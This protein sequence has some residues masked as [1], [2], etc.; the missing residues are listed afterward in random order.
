MKK[1]ALILLFPFLLNLSVS[2]QTL[3]K[4]NQYNVLYKGD[5]MPIITLFANHQIINRLGISGYF[6]VNAYPKSSW[7]EGLIG[8][9][10]TVIDGLTLGFLAG[11][12]SNE[13]RI[14]RISPLVM[15]NFGKFSF[16][17]AFEFW[18]KRYRWDAMAF[19]SV[20]SV[21]FGGEFIRYYQMYAA[22]P[23]I[24]FSF[25]KKQPITIFYSFLWDWSYGYP[26]HMF[27]I[28]TSFGKL[29]RAIDFDE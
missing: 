18:G 6:Y 8:V 28:Y 24:E 9:N 11:F 26:A 14:W 2:G 19:Y 23:R 25:L 1:K 7:G 27:G 16:F 3:F 10:Y 22:G 5:L 17:G 12:Q 13:A 29:T 4:I 21:K 20:S 15:M